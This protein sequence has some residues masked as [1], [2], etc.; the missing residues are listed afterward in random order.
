MKYVN[1]EPQAPDNRCELCPVRHRAVCRALSGPPIRQLGSIMHHY[2]VA[3]GSAIWHEGDDLRQFSIV[4]SG[5]VKLVSVLGDGRQQIVGLLFPSD[6][7]GTVFSHTATTSAE[8]ATDVELCSYDRGQFER[9]MKENP[10]LEHEILGEGRRRSRRGARLDGRARAPVGTGEAGKFPHAA[11]SQMG[12]RPLRPC[13]T[14]LE[15]ADRGDSLT[16]AEIAD[17][18]GMTI[19]TVSRSFSK[20]RAAGLIE[21]LDSRTMMIKDPDALRAIAEIGD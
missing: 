17:Y 18:L 14:R 1:T 15:H 8:A 20:F 13:P 11:L 3:R 19:E 21:L 16:R 10:D 7:I 12:C 9:V 2:N 4:V 5:V 6:W